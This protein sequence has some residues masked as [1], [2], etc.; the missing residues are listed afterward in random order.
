MATIHRARLR[1][2]GLHE[3][4]PATFAVVDDELRLAVATEEVGHWPLREVEAA[5]VDGRVRL[6]VPGEPPLFAAVDEPDEFLAVVEAS[7]RSPRRWRPTGP[8]RRAGGAFRAALA[9]VDARWVIASIAVIGALV[10]AVV[11]AGA[12]GRLL[13]LLGMLAL[14]AAGLLAA[15]DPSAY[16]LVPPGLSEAGLV[17]GGFSAVAVGLLLIFLD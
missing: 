3:E 11:A 17:I 6:D 7:H 5:L 1:I 13:T 4:V 15:D 10:V 12:V 9:S 8:R 2:Q 16:R 14:V